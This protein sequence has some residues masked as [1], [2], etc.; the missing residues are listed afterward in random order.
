MNVELLMQYATY[1]M[2]AIGALAFLVA[3]IVQVIKE[4]PWLQRIQTSLVA[5]VVSLVLCPLAVV[6]VCQYLGIA[7]TLYYIIASIIAAF[8]VY[9]VA[10]G[11]WERVAEMWKR[12][13]YNK[14]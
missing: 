5:F 6:I 2:I 11:G 13:K 8:I 4:L 12:T 14:R 1:V 9:L 10:T 3:A 7:V